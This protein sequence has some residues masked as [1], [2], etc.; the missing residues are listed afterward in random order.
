[1]GYTIGLDWDSGRENGN[2]YDELYPG[3]AYGCCKAGCLRLVV[4]S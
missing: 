4:Q 3:E 2:Y 1:M